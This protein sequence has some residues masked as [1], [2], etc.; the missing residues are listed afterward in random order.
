MGGGLQVCC[1]YQERCW[2]AGVQGGNLDCLSL[3]VR[4]LSI[5][6]REGILL[7]PGDNLRLKA[8][9]QE[10]QAIWMNLEGRVG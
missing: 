7:S 8:R 6:L 4:H 5:A 10:A 1:D 9:L 2:A 3:G